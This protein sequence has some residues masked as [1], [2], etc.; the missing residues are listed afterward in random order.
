MAG[1]R[2]TIHPSGCAVPQAF[3]RQI[4]KLDRVVLPAEIRGRLGSG[5]APPWSSSWTGNT[6]SWAFIGPAV[7]SVAQPSGSGCCAIGRC[8]SRVARGRLGSSVC[9][10]RSNRTGRVALGG[11]YLER[12]SVVKK[13]RRHG[14]WSSKS[15]ARMV[16]RSTPRTGQVNR[17]ISLP[18]RGPDV[19]PPGLIVPG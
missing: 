15:Y 18:A 9:R 11:P 16:G 4:D 17:S 13:T 3:A 5:T 19:V 8:A 14:M 10:W 12:R 1:T 7:C 2:R 6:S